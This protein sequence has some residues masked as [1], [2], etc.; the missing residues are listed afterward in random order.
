M[1]S[2]PTARLLLLVNY[3]PEY[4]HEWGGKAC[5]THFTTTADIDRAIEAG[6]GSRLMPSSPLSTSRR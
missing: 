2:L 1:E 6:N 3:R 5:Y 4:R